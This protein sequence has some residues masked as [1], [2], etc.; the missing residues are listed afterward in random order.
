LAKAETLKKH[1]TISKVITYKI[2]NVL[3]SIISV[4]STPYIWAF[5]LSPFVRIRLARK[6]EDD[7]QVML[8]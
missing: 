7:F 8:I 4:S 5:G 6:E 2:R 3:T 1:I